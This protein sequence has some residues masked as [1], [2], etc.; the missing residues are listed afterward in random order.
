M[1]NVFA[2]FCCELLLLFAF[3]GVFLT[4]CAGGASGGGSDSSEPTG[5]SVRM[6]LTRAAYETADV[7]IFT[8]TIASSSYTDAKSCGQGETLT[9][10]NIPVGS[11]S[12]T[13][14]GKKTDGTVT[15]RGTASVEIEQ[16]V[17]KE[18][19]V[20]LSRLNYY[21]V[22]YKN[23]ASAAD[24]SNYTTQQVTDGYTASSPENP[25]NG[26]RTFSFWS[27][28]R[29]SSTATAFNFN[30]EITADTTL[31]AIW[32][33]TRVTVTYHAIVEGSEVGGVTLDSSYCGTMTY[34]TTDS[35]VSL[36]AAS[37]SGVYAELTFAGWYSSSDYSSESQV[38][39]IDSGTAGTMDLYAKWTCTVSVYKQ[40]DSG[41]QELIGT[42]TV[43]YNG[44][45]TE[46]SESERAITG[47]EF[48]SW[49]KYVSA[50]ASTAFSFDT[51]ITANTI[52]FAT[53][54]LGVTSFNGSV[55]DFSNVTFVSGNAAGA[56]YEVTLT[57]VT[58]DNI[59][60]V[61]AKL[62][63]LSVY[64]SLILQGSITELGDGALAGCTTITS[65]TIPASVTTFWD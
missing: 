39:S 46:P 5:L 8:V 61:K 28:V 15:A 31:Y 22:T 53:W 25:E 20:T 37:R 34:D 41:G 45:A 17:T 62:Q 11:Y 55:S 16:D 18:V 30:S 65:V 35:G 40:Y 13:A 19:S 33:T 57:D 36:P 2:R 4:S 50:D 52:I 24:D 59:S 60:A 27:T 47:Y 32:D 64:I 12:I 43:N 54:A 10:T 58:A 7:Q 29:D 1:K 38:T 14:L 63:S 48:V 56:S 51:P 3:F 9:F 49:K 6:P 21:T 42:Q 26:T 44:T 23:N